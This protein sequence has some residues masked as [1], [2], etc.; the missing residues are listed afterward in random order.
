MN[1][2]LVTGG[3]SILTSAISA[4]VTWILARKKYNS[5]VDS[6]LIANMGKSLEFYEKISDDNKERLDAA[7][8][9]N[10]Q[11]R[12]TVEKLLKEN[13]QLKKDLSLL[14][15]Q[16]IKITTTICTDL[17][18]QIR[19]KDYSTLNMIQHEEVKP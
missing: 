17:S 19:S 10:A 6:N 2:I 13:E 4:I 1:E 3:V 11:L 15:D 14:K 18:C 8:E 9:D 5:E 12:R 16:V 7:L